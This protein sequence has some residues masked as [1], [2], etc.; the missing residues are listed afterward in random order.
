MTTGNDDHAARIWDVATGR[1]LRVLRTHG[2]IWEAEFSPDGKLV[3]TAGGPG[4]A[5][6]W[7]ASNGCQVRLLTRGVDLGSDLPGFYEPGVWDARFSPD[8]TRIVTAD[9]PHLMPD[10]GLVEVWDVSS[11][12]SE[13]I[14]RSNARVSAAD[15]S[16]DGKLVLAQDYTG[17]VMPELWDVASGRKL[18]TFSGRHAVFS[19]DGRLVA[20]TV[21][22]GVQLWDV[23]TGRKGRSF[24]GFNP[25]FSPNG[26]LVVTHEGEPVQTSDG[27]ISVLR[28]GKTAQLWD[29]AR[30]TR[31]HTLSG[32]T[33]RTMFSANGKLLVSISEGTPVPARVAARPRPA[34]TSKR[35]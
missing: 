1:N 20:T 2:Y 14:M 15:F 11:G 18:R 23:A 31:L 9:A 26:A 32:H 21:S 5:R 10:R 27:G 25:V 6:I 4:G 22:G 12:R 17:A 3:V 35:L 29:V 16:P 7:N 34:S 28:A 8:G 13:S 19:P 33:A 30:G 24:P